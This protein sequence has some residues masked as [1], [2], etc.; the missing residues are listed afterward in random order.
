M[1]FV[2]LVCLAV[3]VGVPEIALADKDPE[4]AP[5]EWGV[6]AQV[7]R[8]HVRVGIQ[9]LYFDGSPG[10]ATQDGVGAT[11]VRRSRTLDIVIGFGYDP[12]R[13]VEGYYLSKGGDPTVSATT[14]WA[15]RRSRQNGSAPGGAANA[16]A[17]T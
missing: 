17:A 9:K 4:S 6:G 7:R 15:A 3:G 13:P 10:P 5:I 11:F 14:P 16:V 2:P 8:S 12:I 1:R